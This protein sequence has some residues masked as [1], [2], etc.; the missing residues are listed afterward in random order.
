M[1][2]SLEMGEVLLSEDNPANIYLFKGTSGKGV[3]YVQ[4]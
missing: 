1:K 4:S 2:Y 3:K